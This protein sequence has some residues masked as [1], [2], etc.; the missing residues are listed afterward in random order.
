MFC[1]CFAI[2]TAATKCIRKWNQEAFVMFGIKSVFH[3]KQSENVSVR[4]LFGLNLYFVLIVFYSICANK[5][6]IF[7]FICIRS[8]YKCLWFRFRM[9]IIS[10]SQSSTFSTLLPNS[11]RHMPP[12]KNITCNATNLK[13]DISHII[14]NTLLEPVILQFEFWIISL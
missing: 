7:R 3:G 13:T 5:L 2:L 8:I 10:L 14:S 12:Q 6:F 1:N 4:K 11:L 9:H